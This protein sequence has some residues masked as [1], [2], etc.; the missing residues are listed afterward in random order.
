ML[1]LLAL[2]LLVTGVWLWFE[3]RPSA[4]APVWSDPVNPRQQGVHRMRIVHHVASTL[5]MSAAA[6]LG[7]LL[8]LRRRRQ[9]PI[10]LLVPA[11]AVAGAFTGYL[12]AWD[13]LALS[14]VTVGTDLSGLRAAF[15]ERV[16]YVLVE[17]TEVAA[18]TF[19]RWAAL[20]VA[21]LPVAAAI[22]GLVTWVRA[23]RAR[24]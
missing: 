18:G 8:V 3:Y 21:L 17:G 5:A 19:R 13:Q 4:T 6:A 15:D 12:V 24:P 16:V 1:G 2:V 7:V 9:W 14:S 11:A 23:R 20:H 10:A 22:A